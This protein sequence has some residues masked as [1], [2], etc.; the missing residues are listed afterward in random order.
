M[1]EIED[2]N[3]P[4]IQ[5]EIFGP[6]LVIERFQDEAEAVERANATRYGLAASVWTE[7]LDQARRVARKIRTGTVWSNTH[8]KLFAEAETGGHHDSGYGR[9]HGVEGLNDFLATKHFYYEV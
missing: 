9:L 7:R 8:N 5:E 1:V 3:S 6:F 2:L 4:L